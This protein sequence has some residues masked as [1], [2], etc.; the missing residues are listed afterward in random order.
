MINKMLGGMQHTEVLAYM[1]DIL[2]PSETVESGLALLKRVLIEQVAG[3]FCKYVEDFAKGD[4][5]QQA[6]FQLMQRLVNRPVLVIYACKIGV[7]A[8]LLQQ[9][10]GEDWCPVVY[11]SQNTASGA[12]V[13]QL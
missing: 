12:G 2:I 9:Q 7:G 3:Y 5:E 8:I 10:A 6:F 4:E 13:P 11:C 1:D